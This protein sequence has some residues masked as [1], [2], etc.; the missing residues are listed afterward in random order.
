MILAI[1]LNLAL[2]LFGYYLGLKKAKKDWEEL[3][4]GSD[5]LKSAFEYYHTSQLEEAEDTSND[6]PPVD[7]GAVNVELNS[8]SDRDEDFINY[9]EFKQI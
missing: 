8:K 6:K 7:A 5:I 3:I 2:I 1:V 9:K 4:N